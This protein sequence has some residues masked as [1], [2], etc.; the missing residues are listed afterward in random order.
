MNSLK[1]LVFG[2]KNKIYFSYRFGGRKK[3]KDD[4]KCDRCSFKGLRLRGLIEYIE[5][6]GNL[7]VELKFEF[8]WFKQQWYLNFV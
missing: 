5:E 8:K 2:N 6:V 3:K 7:E 4:R 1:C